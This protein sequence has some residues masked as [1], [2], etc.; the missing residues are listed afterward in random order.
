M[1]TLFVLVTFALLSSASAVAHHG[2]G[3]YQDADFQITGTVSTPVSTAG[4]HASLKITVDGQVWNVVLAPPARTVAAGL[5][6]GIIPVG[7]QVTAFGHRHRDP[8][9]LEI[10]TERL[11][12]NGRT[13]NVYPDRT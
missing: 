6:E 5:K 12:W 7:A 4:P 8:K 10:K 3:G 9:T 1:K 11:N 13:F 2:W